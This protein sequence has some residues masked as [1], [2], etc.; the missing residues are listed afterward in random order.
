MAKHKT[1]QVAEIFTLVDSEGSPRVMWQIESETQMPYLTIHDKRG[2]D[3]IAIF[4]KDNGDPAISLN[5]ADGTS[6]VSIGIQDEMNALLTVN[7]SNGVPAV[8]IVVDDLTV[9]RLE[10]YAPDG[11]C[12]WKQ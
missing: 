4:L 9:A 7:Y 1:Q 3:R 5:R 6:A 8:K 12:I 2:R 11:K 10:I